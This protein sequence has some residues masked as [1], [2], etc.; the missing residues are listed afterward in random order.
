M[1]FVESSPF[2]IC[3]KCGGNFKPKYP[4]CHPFNELICDCEIQS[5]KPNLK[6][7]PK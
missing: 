1:G 3:D 5:P 2:G 7:E 4:P 6:E